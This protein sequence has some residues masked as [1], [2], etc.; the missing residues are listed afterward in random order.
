VVLRLR[1]RGYEAVFVVREGFEAWLRADGLADSIQDGMG[2]PTQV[3]IW[4]P[5]LAF[6]LVK[7]NRTRAQ[8]VWLVAD[9][10]HLWRSR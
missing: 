8:L 3:L 1:E 10:R 6:V 7:K 5:G 4:T 2:L 9:V